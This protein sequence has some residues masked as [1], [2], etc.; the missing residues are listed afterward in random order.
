MKAHI[1]FGVLALGLSVAF[2]ADDAG[3]KSI[4]NGKD[5]TGWEGRTNHWSVENGAI[6]GV[7]TKE[8]PAKGNNFLIWRP[9]GTNEMVN[10]IEL[11]FSYK[12]V[13][14]GEKGFGNSG[15]QYR[16]KDFENFVVGG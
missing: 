12:I 16:S 6:T 13:P 2:A 11:R 5:L 3:F 4:F 1:L 7:T 8:N 14:N 15:V 9:N 10:N